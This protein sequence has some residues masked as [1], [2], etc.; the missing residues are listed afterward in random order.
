MLKNDLLASVRLIAFDF[1]GDLTDNIVYNSQYGNESI[2]CW[3][4]KGIGLTPLREVEVETF[5][6]STEANTVARARAK[7]IKLPCKQDVK[8]KV[9]E[10][11]AICKKLENSPQ[12]VMLHIYYYIWR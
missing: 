6:I 8:V 12:Q 11:L 7:K 1:D 3:R 5:I 9:A 4:S 2:R 10:I